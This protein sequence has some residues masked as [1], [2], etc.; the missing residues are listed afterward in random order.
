[1]EDRNIVPCRLPPHTID[2]L[3]LLDVVCVQPLKYC[4]AEGIDQAIHIRDVDSDKLAFLA[5]IEDIR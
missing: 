4:H 1:M 3:Q 5:A 2:I